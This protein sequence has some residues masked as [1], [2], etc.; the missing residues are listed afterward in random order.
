MLAMLVGI[1]VV[2]VVVVDDGDDDGGT[3]LVDVVSRTRNGEKIEKK[4]EKGKNKEREREI[5]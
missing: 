5:P 1:V 3:R 4:E 2:V